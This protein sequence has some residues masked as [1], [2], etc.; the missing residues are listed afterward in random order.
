M[1]TTAANSGQRRGVPDQGHRTRGLLLLSESRSDTGMRRVSS[2]I[3]LRTPVHVA[4]VQTCP[5][6]RGCPVYGRR[7][8]GKA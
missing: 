4:M 5:P 8:T 3:R 7:L 2:A 1:S 6:P